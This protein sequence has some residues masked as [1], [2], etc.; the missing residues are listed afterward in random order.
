MWEHGVLQPSRP[1]HR[2]VLVHTRVCALALM[3]VQE[4]A[5]QQALERLREKNGGAEHGAKIEL[6]LKPMVES[7]PGT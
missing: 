4:Q 3:C 6:L 5:E 7:D 1:A 2:A